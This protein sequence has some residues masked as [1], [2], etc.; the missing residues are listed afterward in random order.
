MGLEPS[1]KPVWSPL[2]HEIYREIRAWDLKNPQRK[3]SGRRLLLACS[4]GLD[5]SVLLKVL[6][7]LRSALNLE[8]AVFHAHH[9][10]SEN[11]VL[12]SYRDQA[13]L[14]VENQARENKLPFFTAKSSKVLRSEAELRDFRKMEVS[15][16]SSRWNA[17]LIVWAHHQND[18]LETQM[19]RLIRGTGMM[20]L[21]AM[22]WNDEKNLRPFLRVSRNELEKEALSQKLHFVEDPS[23]QETEYLRNWL[24]HDWFPQ[25]EDKC[26]GALQSLGGSL[27]QMAQVWRE[28]HQ[29]EWPPELWVEGGLSRPHFLTLSTSEQ[30]QCLAQ[31]L[32]DL[33]SQN[34]TQNHLREVMKHL[35]IPES[36]HRFECAQM[37]WFL[38]R[39]RIEARPVSCS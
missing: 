24:R 27:R 8:I 29:P 7:E 22:S 32:R 39:D 38:S 31:Y 6:C 17:D 9:G 11:P 15:K 33:G 37:T 25:L 1:S 28:T 20:G 30:V 23:N 35:D 19:I 18:L 5:S 34:Y 3:I 12:Q 2:V 26:P 4:G 16:V 10:F 13:L 14:V 21:E 36:E